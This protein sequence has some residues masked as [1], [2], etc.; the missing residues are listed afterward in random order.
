MGFCARIALQNGQVVSIREQGQ[1][2]MVEH[3][4]EDG[5]VAICHTGLPPVLIMNTEEEIFQMCAQNHLY[6]KIVEIED[7]EVTM[8][9]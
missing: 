5:V 2:Q 3:P 6:A 4:L 9:E 1:P 7:V 8:K